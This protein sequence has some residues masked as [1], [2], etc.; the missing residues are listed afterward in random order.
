[1]S[2]DGRRFRRKPEPSRLQRMARDGVYG[3]LVE[4]LSFRGHLELFT[5]GTV[6]K[7]I[8]AWRDAVRETW[9]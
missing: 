1:M 4:G 3:W 5:V 9:P 7:A 6:D 2:H 8:K